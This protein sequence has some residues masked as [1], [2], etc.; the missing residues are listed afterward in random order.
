MCSFEKFLVLVSG[1]I[2]VTVCANSPSTLCSVRVCLCVRR[3]A[4]RAG[5]VVRTGAM[6][7]LL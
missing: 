6:K 1:V 7:S 5:A 3:S 2:S 4:L